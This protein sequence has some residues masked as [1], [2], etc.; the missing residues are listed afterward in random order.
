MA[1]V[2]VMDHILRKIESHLLD[3]LARDKSILLLGPR[4]T[5]KTTLLARIPAAFSVSFIQPRVRLRYEKDPS[6]LAD[7]VEV[8]CDKSEKLP[9]IIV[10]EVQKVPL[11][12]DVVQDL[13]DRKIAKFILTGSSARK[14][15]RNESINLLPGRVFVLHMDALSYD[16]LKETQSS[17]NDLMIYGSLPEIITTQ[18]KEERDELLASYVSIY[19]EEEVRAEA[20]IR[21]LSHFARFLELAA[22]ES[23]KVVNYL[24]LSQEINVAHTTIAA[25]YQILEDCLIVARIEPYLKT[26]TRRRL[27]KSQKYLFF[28]LGVRRA[29]ANEGTCLPFQYMDHLFEQFVALEVLRMLRCCKKRASLYYWRDLD[30]PEVD[31]VISYPGKLIP[32][33]VKWT[34]TPELRHARHL[35][36]FIKEY[37]AAKKGYLVCRIP[38][39]MKLSDSIY[40][41]PWQDLVEIVGDD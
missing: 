15:K 6:I 16:E 10:D 9:L 32:I 39:K 19:L 33:E 27:S 38:R 26:K 7:E 34:D 3:Y 12:M 31:W 20:I 41:I 24:K 18:A 37:D 23:G 14:L 36:I 8:L 21:N 25:Y 28:D 4:Q 29:A 11:I 30:G 2:D 5:G 1:I 13:I 22:S 17:L 35:S 40:A